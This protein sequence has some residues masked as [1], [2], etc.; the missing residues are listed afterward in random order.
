MTPVRAHSTLMELTQNTKCVESKMCV[1]R[2]PPPLSDNQFVTRNTTTV[3]DNAGAVVAVCSGQKFRFSD[4][5]N[6]KRR[7]IW[8]LYTWGQTHS[9]NGDAMNDVSTGKSSEGDAPMAR[10]YTWGQTHG[11][12]PN[13]ER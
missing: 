12:S 5:Q 8:R 13:T 6:S 4:S 10:L 11:H 9:I 7:D 3:P 1:C 2:I